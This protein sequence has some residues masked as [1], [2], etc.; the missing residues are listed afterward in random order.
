MAPIGQRY[1]DVCN[2][3]INRKNFS[4]HLKTKR[5]VRMEVHSRKLQS[6]Q[7]VQHSQPLKIE[8]RRKEEKTKIRGNDQYELKIHDQEKFQTTPF[9]NIQQ[10][11]EQISK[12]MHDPSVSYTCDSYEGAEE[13]HFEANEEEICY[14]RQ[15][16]VPRGIE[17]ECVNFQNLYDKIVPFPPIDSATDENSNLQGK[18][19]QFARKADNS[20][21]KDLGQENKEKNIPPCEFSRCLVKTELSHP[22]FPF[23]RQLGTFQHHQFGM[24]LPEFLKLSHCQE[25]NFHFLRCRDAGTNSNTLFTIPKY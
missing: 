11:I 18:N 17:E 20:E 13:P 22:S 4:Q 10:I 9:S 19:D 8:V 12:S 23:T 15:N 21:P 6:G 5:H 24:K 7:E 14:D 3:F 16:A 1:C 25:K 2:V